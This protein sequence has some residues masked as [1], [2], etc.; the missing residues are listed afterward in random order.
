MTND[1]TAL[2]CL[3][4]AEF[5]AIGVSLKALSYPSLASQ[6]HQITGVFIILMTATF[7]WTWRTIGKLNVA[8]PSR[9][10]QE[11]KP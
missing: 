7:G 10:E 1:R 3:Q 4:F 2:Y 11:P 8:P 9:A 6:H 5:I